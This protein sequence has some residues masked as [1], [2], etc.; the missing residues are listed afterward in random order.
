MQA[1]PRCTY[2][3]TTNTKKN[4]HQHPVIIRHC[5]RCGGTFLDPGDAASLYGEWADVKN[6]GQLKQTENLGTSKLCC[7]SGHGAMKSYLVSSKSNAVEIDS[8]ET[9]SGLW[10]DRKESKKLY[11]TL[12]EIEKEKQDGDD[13]KEEDDDPGIISYIFQLLTGFPIEAWNPTKNIPWLVWGTIAFLVVVFVVQRF[14]TMG[15]T[16][17]QSQNLFNNWGVV[18]KEVLGG[19]ALWTL[20]TY[21]FI[22]AG[23]VH[24]LGNIYYLYVFGD[25][26]EDT[27]GR[28]RFFLI[29]GL[30]GLAGALLHVAI[31]PKETIALVGA[32][33]AISGLMGAYLVLFPKVQ[34]WTVIILFRFKVSMLIYMLFWL[35]IQIFMIFMY[36]KGVAWFAHLGGFFVG[37]ILAFF[38]R[39]LSPAYH[40]D[41]AYHQE[42]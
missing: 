33:G 27:L 8:C 42:N 36:A 31:F 34:V 37:L 29:Y 40:Q 20:I 9:C 28:W 12:K 10:F 17:T 16:E 4:L 18:P 23:I 5:K 35:G 15:M 19:N 32:S 7:P 14:F 11:K 38:F 39:S 22:H 2:P 13:G 21:A 41:P 6:W 25:N 24:L 30:S 3:L 26:V 1:C